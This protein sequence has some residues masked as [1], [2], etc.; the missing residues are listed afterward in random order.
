MHH[1][2]TPPHFVRSFWRIDMTDK[3]SWLFTQSGVIP[4][5]SRKGALEI[6]LITSRKQK[7]LVIPKGVVEPG[8]SPDESALN[9]AYEE[10][11]IRGE[12]L[13]GPIGEYT[14]DKWGNTCHVT[15]FLLRVTEELDI[16]PEASF[17]ERSWMSAGKA[18]T[19]VEESKLGAMITEVPFRVEQLKKKRK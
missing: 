10:A 17:R 8:M 1:F 15:V 18:A 5:R 11:G 2:S 16:W 4:F 13:G 9:E 6:L 19:S 3:P 14:Y 12:I 7:R